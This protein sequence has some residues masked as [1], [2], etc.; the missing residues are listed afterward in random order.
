MIFVTIFVKN[1]I[2]FGGGVKNAILAYI[3]LWNGIQQRGDYYPENIINH[4]FVKK[5][6]QYGLENWCVCKN[7]NYLLL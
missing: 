6:W 2:F 1:A 3:S 4:N 7:D 5:P